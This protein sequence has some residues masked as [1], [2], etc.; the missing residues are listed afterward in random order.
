LD[1]ELEETEMAAVLERQRIAV[2]PTGAAL[3]ADIEGVDLARELSPHAVD[4]TKQAWA[5]HLVLRFRGQRLDDDQLMRFSAHFGELDWAPVIAASRV[6]V[7]GEDRYVESAEEGRRYISVISNIV[8]NGRAIGALGAY[9]SIWH[10]DMSYN[11]EPPCASALYALE[12][13][14]SGGDTGFANMYRAYETMPDEL[15][16]Q[17]EGRLCRHDSTYNSAGELRRG[18]SEVTDPREAPGADHPIIRTHPVTGRRALFLGRRRNAYILGLELQDSERLLD[19]LW[20]HA[21]RPELTWYQQWRVGDLV[22]WDNRCVMHRRDEFD[23]NSR[24]L[25]HR[26]QIRGDRPH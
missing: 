3:G 15:R 21:G 26:S 5:D 1:F 16:Q 4:A 7:P 18:S 13:P 2:K 24:R 12:V 25:M 8:E 11:P 17:V 14:P 6:K 23:P 9:E 10:T 20:A 22:L 19:A